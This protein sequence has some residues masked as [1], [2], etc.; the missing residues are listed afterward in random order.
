MSFIAVKKDIV[1]RKKFYNLKLYS[2][3]QNTLKYIIM[4]IMIFFFQ[5]LQYILNKKCSFFGQKN[6]KMGLKKKGPGKPILKI[7]KK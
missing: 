4:M 7:M 2:G 3:G 6:L 5:P 1:T